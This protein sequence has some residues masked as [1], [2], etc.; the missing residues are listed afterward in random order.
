MHALTL[1]LTQKQ[2]K[3]GVRVSNFRRTKRFL[4]LVLSARVF[5][6]YSLYVTVNSEWLIATSNL[7]HPPYDV[8]NLLMSTAYVAVIIGYV[9]SA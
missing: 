4:L 2:N 9:T 6:T 7:H 5:T 8:C 1:F 3:T